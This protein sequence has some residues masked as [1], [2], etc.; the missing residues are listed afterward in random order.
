MQ[1]NIQEDVNESRQGVS[2]V[3]VRMY[4]CLF[5]LPSLYASVSV[6]TTVRACLCHCHC[7]CVFVSVIT[8]VV[9]S[10]VTIIVRV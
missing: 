4:M 10:L 8:T 7:V 5:L 2:F 3:L 6:T 1:S 9:S